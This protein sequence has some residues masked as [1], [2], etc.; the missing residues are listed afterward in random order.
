MPVFPSVEW[1]DAV[2]RVTNEDEE[3]RSLGT[4]DAVM[5][6][7]VDGQAYEVRFEAFGYAGAR[8]I[9][10][11]DLDFVDFYL[12]QGLEGWREMLEHIR[13]QGRADARHG[14]LARDLELPDGL[15]KGDDWLRRGRFSR[16]ARSLQRYFDLS[17]RMK[18][19][20]PA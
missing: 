9:T 11:R 18:T 19:T 14:L 6:V 20:Y 13:A 1:F 5:G 8:E 10:P 16:F 7:K 2:G 15:A 17:G 12:E 3:F 4:C